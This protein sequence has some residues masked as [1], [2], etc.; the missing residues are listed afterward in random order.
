MVSVINI[1]ECIEVGRCDDMKWFGIMYSVM[2]LVYLIYSVLCRGK[3]NYYNRKYIRKIEMTIIKSSE[4]LSLQL[5]FS[6][7]NSI[8]L[9]MYGILIII[10]NLNNVFIIAGSLPFLLLNF[11]LIVE[12]KGKGYVY[13]K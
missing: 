7:L 13:Y 8:Y 2:G 6:I 3:V 9:I 11:L 5:K 12:S 4:F 1:G 10:F